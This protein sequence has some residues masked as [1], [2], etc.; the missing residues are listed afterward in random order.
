MTTLSF[1]TM[2]AQ[3]ERFENLAAFRAAVKAMGYDAIEVSHSTEQPGL[4]TLLGSKSLPVSSLHAPT[5]RRKLQDGRVNGDAN[6]A[7]VNE[8]E[9]RMAVDEHIRS[10][11]YC[12]QYRIPLLVVHLGGVGNYMNETERNLRRSVEAGDGESEQAQQLRHDLTRWRELSGGPWLAAARRSLKELVQV[13]SPAGVVLGLES[14]LHYNEIPHPQEA[15][16]LLSEH[17]PEAAG[18]WHDVGHCEVQAR[19]GMIDRYAW[20]PALTS[21]TVGSHLHDVDGIADHRAPGNG[22]VDWSYIAAGLPPT[23][24][25]VF[26]IDQRQPD[27]K[28][29]AAIAFLKDRGVV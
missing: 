12:A 26:E 9:R 29:A 18:Y 27:D 21:R 4:Q 15:L 10:I 11:K 17:P 25:R 23:A 28:V 16:D 5:P 19:L 2:W 22:D 6:L 24:L 1:S 14:R 8:D 3:Q 13:A 7:S 20:F